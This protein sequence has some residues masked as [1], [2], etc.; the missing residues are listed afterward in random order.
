MKKVVSLVNFAPAALRSRVLQHR[1]LGGDRHAEAVHDPLGL[2][3]ELRVIGVSEQEQ[4]GL[5]RQIGELGLLRAVVQ[6]G[7]A[8]RLIE[9]KIQHA[10][11][12][13]TGRDAERLVNCADGGRRDG[14]QALFAHEGHAD[15]GVFGIVLKKQN[16]C[17]G[18]ANQHPGAR[19][20]LSG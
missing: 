1:V 9:R 20:D 11:R 5:D 4:G 6:G 15:S 13:V 12:T 7:G 14:A 3:L 2:A 16:R 19:R 18:T 17:A 10:E 8:A